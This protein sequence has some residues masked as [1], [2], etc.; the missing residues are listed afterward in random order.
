[1]GWED[2]IDLKKLEPILEKNESI[3]KILNLNFYKYLLNI[4]YNRKYRVNFSINILINKW[5]ILKPVFLKSLIK[6]YIDYQI[7][8]YS[9]TKIKIY[10]LNYL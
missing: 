1:M 8:R 7:Q 4:I 2:D 6:K 3:S 10:C 9:D 5:I